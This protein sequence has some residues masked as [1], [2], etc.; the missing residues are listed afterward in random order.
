RLAE[1]ASEVARAR[2][3]A[4][5][6]TLANARTDLEIHGQ[7]GVALAARVSFVE[8]RLA[9]GEEELGERLAAIERREFALRREQQ[10]AQQ[11]VES[12]ER[13]LAAAQRRADAEVQPGPAL[14]AEVETRR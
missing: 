5:E 9:V 13:R 4:E 11:A 7:A 1:L 12:A 8:E 10:D 2:V 6:L 14:V 3:A